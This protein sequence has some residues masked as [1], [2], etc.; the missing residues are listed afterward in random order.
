MSDVETS[1]Q[2]PLDGAALPLS[3]EA[4]AELSARLLSLKEEDRLDILD[5]RRVAIEDWQR[6]DEHYVLA[7]TDEMRR[8]SMDRA[9]TYA[10]KCAAEIERRA[11][12]NTAPLA[13]AP[14]PEPVEA[15]ATR[16]AEVPVPL[17][18]PE[19][20]VPTFLQQH[21]APGGAFARV[22]RPPEHLA[23]TAMAFELPTALRSKATAALPFQPGAAPTL[24]AAPSH[25]PAPAP[26]G[27]ETIGLGVDLIAQMRGTLPFAKSG[28]AAP[29]VA[30]PRLPLQTY[31]SFCA[32][33]SVFPERTAAILG[34][35]HV[36]S[37]D[38]R[39]ALVQEWQAR[40]DAHAD[41]RAEWQRHF[42]SFCAWLR[43]QPR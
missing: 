40:L 33:L 7:L 22:Q 24:P 23:G 6:C 43:Q 38:A 3:F 8:G 4:W 1:S 19:T 27:G 42:D 31:A 16:T 12:A 14:T 29:R 37:E 26:T 17:Q 2:S 36:P 25:P 41:T 35:Y 10:G 15:D 39:A 13:D 28:A 32:E 34:K 21:E 11:T 18:A 9:R 20:A 30:F 5:D